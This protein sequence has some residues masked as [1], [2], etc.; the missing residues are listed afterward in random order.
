MGNA[1][2]QQIEKFQEQAVEYDEAREDALNSK[3]DFTVAAIGTLMTNLKEGIEE[4]TECASQKP[5]YYDKELCKTLNDTVTK[6]VEAFSKIKAPTV[7]VAPPQVNIDLS[8]IHSIAESISTQN[9]SLIGL[10]DKVG[11]GNKSD[12]LHRMIIEMVGK[13]NEFLRNAFKQADYT[14][15]FDMIIQILK[16]SRPIVEKLHIQRNGYNTEIVPVYKK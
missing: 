2:Q 6:L 12:E 9:K 14:K 10:L 16:D 8:S 7:N 15:Q 1:L 11:S 3:T 13:Q 5:Q 4:L